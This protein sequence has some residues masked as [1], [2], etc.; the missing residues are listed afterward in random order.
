MVGSYQT[1]VDRWFD[2]WMDVLA[3]GYKRS[4]ID[5]GM[6]GTDALEPG[7]RNVEMKNAKPEVEGWWWWG[8]GDDMEENDVARGTFAPAGLPDGWEN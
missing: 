5:E 7:V 4:R 3:R 1:G 8:A 2:G 6:V